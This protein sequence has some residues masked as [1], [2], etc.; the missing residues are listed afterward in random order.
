MPRPRTVFGDEL[1]KC[2]HAEYL[3]FGCVKYVSALN[4][5]RGEELAALAKIKIRGNLNP[6]E[7][8]NIAP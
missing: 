3:A 4:R 7:H 8:K 2:H 6:D 1:R 5:R